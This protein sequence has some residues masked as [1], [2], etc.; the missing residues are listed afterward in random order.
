MHERASL[1]EFGGTVVINKEWAKSVLRRLGYT[2]R[3]GN[4]KSKILPEN[5]RAVPN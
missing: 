2:K 4:S 5:L 1:E 3:R